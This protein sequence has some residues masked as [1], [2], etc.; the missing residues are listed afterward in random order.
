[1]LHILPRNRR[2]LCAV[3]ERIMNIFLFYYSVGFVDYLKI[4]TH[5]RNANARLSVVFSHK[6]QCLGP[7]VAYRYR[8]VVY[9]SNNDSIQIGLIIR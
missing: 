6:S 2:L 1:M 9:K 4:I 3:A 7:P 8:I 5:L